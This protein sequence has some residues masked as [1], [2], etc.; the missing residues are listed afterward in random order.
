[1]RKEHETC[2][3][4]MTEV[5]KYHLQHVIVPSHWKGAKNLEYKRGALGQK[6]VEEQKKVLPASDWSMD[7]VSPSLLRERL[8]VSFASPTA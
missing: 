3:I 2:N 5:A 6:E 1:M 4:C 8:L 7:C